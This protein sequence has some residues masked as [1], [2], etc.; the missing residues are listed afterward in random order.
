ML[1]QCNIKVGSAR[2]LLP[3]NERKSYFKCSWLYP[4]SFF[5]LLFS[6]CGY[7]EPLFTSISL[8]TGKV[9]SF[10]SS[11]AWRGLW[12]QP[13]AAVWAAEICSSGEMPQC[14]TAQ[15]HPQLQSAWS[16]ALQSCENILKGILAVLGLEHLPWSFHNG[17][18]DCTDKNIVRLGQEAEFL[19]WQ[20][21]Y[22][23]SALFRAVLKN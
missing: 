10:V 5:L 20:K 3:H 16:G 1:S 22:H 14:S 6:W 15:V 21:S 9:V 18:L 13:G 19:F 23:S 4:N 17:S 7:M 12:N 2:K 8:S 11:S